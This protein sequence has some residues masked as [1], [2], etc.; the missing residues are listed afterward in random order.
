MQ[1]SSGVE[2]P[3]N[4]TS[5]VPAPTYRVKETAMLKKATSQA[6]LIVASSL[7][8]YREMALSAVSLF[9]R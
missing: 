4:D 9:R 8:L 5:G 2:G 7:D 6:T 1:A 3:R